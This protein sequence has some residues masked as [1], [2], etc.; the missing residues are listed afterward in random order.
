ML[1]RWARGGSTVLRN[2]IRFLLADPQCGQLSVNSLF[3][4]SLLVVAA[5]GFDGLVAAIGQSGRPSLPVDALSDR[6]SINSDR[7]DV[8]SGIVTNL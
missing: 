4:S 2:S 5:S 3:W 6:Q 7:Y 1:Y 8:A